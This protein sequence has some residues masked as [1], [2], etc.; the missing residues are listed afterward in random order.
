MERVPHPFAPV[1]QRVRGF[2]KMRNK[3]K[4]FYGQ[5]QLYWR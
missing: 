2:P 5:G 4:R 3:L 1:Q